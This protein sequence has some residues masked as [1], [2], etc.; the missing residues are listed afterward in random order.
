MLLICLLLELWT[1]IGALQTEP[2]I[3]KLWLELDYVYVMVLGWFYG[4]PGSF[5]SNLF[6]FSAW[7]SL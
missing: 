1:M 4:P 6:T 3:E 2:T 7:E 5:L